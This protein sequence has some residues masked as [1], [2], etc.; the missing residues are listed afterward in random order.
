MRFRKQKETS[1]LAD[2]DVECMLALKK[3][4]RDAFEI[5]MRKYYPRILNFVYGRLARCR[6]NGEDPYFI[7][8]ATPAGG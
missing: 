1:Y 3:G 6:A 8:D 2:P 4:D 5:L 7:S